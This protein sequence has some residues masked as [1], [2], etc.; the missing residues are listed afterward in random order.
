[1]NEN[2]QKF[3]FKA[4]IDIKNLKQACQICL[5]PHAKL[6]ILS[7]NTRQNLIYLN[8]IHFKH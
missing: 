2:I 7:I 4:L 3:V 8:C 6:S 1:M 5:P